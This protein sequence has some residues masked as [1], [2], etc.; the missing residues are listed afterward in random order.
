VLAIIDGEHYPP[1]VVDALAALSATDEV[2]GAVL[3]GG[4]EK[5]AGSEDPY[6]VPLVRGR[7]DPRDPLGGQAAALAEAIAL[8]APEV[9]VDLSDEPVVGYRERFF[10]ASHAL[11]AGLDYRGAGFTFEAPRYERLANRPSIAVVGT[12]KRVGKTAVSA[13]LARRLKTAGLLPVVV[14]MGRG[15]PS[16]PELVR[17][18]LAPPTVDDLMARAATGAHAASD[19]F[20]DAVMSEVPT[21]G[22]RRCGGGLTGQSFADTVHTGA[23]LANTVDEAK[24][25]IYE[26]SGS[27]TPPVATDAA[28]LVAPATQPAEYLVGLFGTYRL[29]RSDLLVVTM[30]EPEVSSAALAGLSDR[31]RSE[32]PGL[33]IIHTVFRPKPLQEV[34]GRRTFLLATAAPERLGTL[35][36]HLESRYGCEVVGASANLSDR[37][38]LEEDIRNAAPF[39]VLLTE[40]KAAAMDVAATQARSRGAEIVLMDNEPVDAGEPGALEEA[41]D[42]L[43]RTAL[44]RFTPPA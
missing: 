11:A 13:Y 28:L 34:R 33:P 17:G 39:E 12:G 35:G 37:R 1:V 19:Y 2:V 25:H 36:A 16:E 44:E 41:L 42:S 14:A 7:V 9:V 22:C 27:A 23:L 38:A 20:E 40:L 32:R 30:C 6:G 3:V 26:G 15:G 5:L 10:L 8:F 43:T 31:V 24:T 18:D 21:V 29:L 4:T